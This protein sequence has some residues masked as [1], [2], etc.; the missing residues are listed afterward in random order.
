MTRVHGT[1][2]AARVADVL[3]TFIDGPEAIGVSAIAR[4]LDLSKAVVHRTLQSLVD[5]Q[6]VAY[7]SR[8]RAYKLGPASAALG[9]RALRESDLRTVAM[10]VLRELQ[11]LTGETTTVSALVPGGRVYL[12]QIESA[13]EIKMTV[14]VGRRYP[15]HA[16]ASS[17]SILAFLPLDERA[18]V[19]DGALQARTSETLTDRDRLVASLDEVRRV[20]YAYSDGERQADAGSVAAPIFGFDGSVRGSISVCGPRARVDDEARARFIPPLLESADTI[21]RALG[22]HGGLPDA[23]VAP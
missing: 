7:E 10:P 15:L 18:E 9:A 8:S 11:H 14:E 19:I 2:S 21:S 1:E 12:D 5:R 3:L 22:W 23:D 17:R 16:G 6:L 13:Q 20:G 4:R